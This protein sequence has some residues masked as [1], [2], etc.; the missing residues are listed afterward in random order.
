MTDLRESNYEGVWD[1]RLGF[2]SK[3]A[4]VSVDFERGYTTRGSPFFAPGVVAAVDQAA[5][6]LQQARASDL[7]VVHTHVV[8]DPG[9]LNGGVW[10][11]KAPALMALAA[12]TQ[13]VE[14]IPE[15]APIDGEVVFQKQYPSAFFGTSLTALLNVRRVDTVILMGCTTSGCI[16]ATAVDAISYG[17]R[18]IVVRECV[19]DRHPEPHEANLFDIDAKYGDVVPLDDALAWLRDQTPPAGRATP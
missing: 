19:G 18:P 5:R 7:L 11:R 2:G 15:V 16:R 6:L 17:F 3:A 1:G 12:G 4:L 8:Y 14:F 10:I 9:G 13:A